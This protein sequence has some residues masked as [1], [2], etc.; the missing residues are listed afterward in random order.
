ME[1]F[2]KRCLRAFLRR[3]RPVDAVTAVLAAWLLFVFGLPIAA[4]NWEPRAN[5]AVRTITNVS[6]STANG[7]KKA[8]TVI[9]INVA[10]SGSVKPVYTS[11]TKPYLLLETGATDREAYI[12]TS[13]NSTTSTLAFSYTVQSGDLSSDLDYVSASS[14]VLN[15]GTIQDGTDNANLTLPTPGTAGSLGANA[16]LVIDGVR[17]T[18]TGVSSST[19]D[20]WY[21]VGDVIYVDVTFS[22]PVTQTSASLYLETGPSD[23]SAAYFAG[24]ASDTI[25]F[26]YQPS[27]GDG[28]TDL[29]YVATTSL[30][31]SFVDAAGNYA[32]TTLAA[33]GGAGSLSANKQIGVLQFT[34][35]NP[36]TNHGGAV[37]RDPA[38]GKFYLDGMGPSGPTC[39][40]REVSADASTISTWTS[41]SNYID[42][43]QVVGSDLYWNAS[44]VIYKSPLAAPSVSTVATATSKSVGAF[45]RLGGVNYVVVTNERKVYRLSDG[46]TTPVLVGS[47]PGTGSSLYTMYAAAEDGYALVGDS[48][49][50]IVYKMNL[51]TGA[52]TVHIDLNKCEYNAFGA[53]EN[54]GLRGIM[55]TA[56]GSEYYTFYS[57]SS[58]IGRRS[59]DGT[60]GCATLHDG[61]SNYI[62]ASF[63]ATADS[64]ALYTVTSVDNMNTQSGFMK[65][66]PN[67]QWG[68]PEVRWA[69]SGD[70]SGPSFTAMTVAS[71][72]L[73]ISLAASEN[74]STGSGSPTPSQFA[75]TVNGASLALASLS[76]SG[77]SLTLVPSSAIANGA[78]VRVVY[79]DV[80]TADDSSTVQDLTGNDAGSVELF[81]VSPRPAAPTALSLGSGT[82][83]GSSSSDRVTNATTLVVVGTAPAASTVQLYVGG[84][85]SGSTCTADSVTGAFSCSTAALPA[86]MVSITAI[87]TAAS[88]VTSAASAAMGVTIDTTAPGAPT[89]LVLD[90]SSDSGT[91]STDRLTNVSSPTINGTAEV[92]AVVQLFVGGVASG[93]GCAAAASTGSFACTTAV[94]TDGDRDISAVA[95]DAAGNSSA[96]STSITVAIDTTGPTISALNL[97]DLTCRPTWCDADFI[98]PTAAPSFVATAPNDTRAQLY[99]GGVAT[100]SIC[101]TSNG[102]GSG[103]FQCT[104]SSLV[105]GTYSVTAKLLDAAGNF[106]ANTYSARSFRVIAGYIPTTSSTVGST[107][108]TTTPGPTTTV[109]ATT[110]TVAGTTSTT[111]S[112]TSSSTTSTTAAPATTASTTSTTLPAVAARPV[113]YVDSETGSDANPGSQASPLRTFTRA[114]A[115]AKAGD[116]ID[117]TG[118]FSWS[119][120]AETGDVAGAGFRIAKA[121]TIRG[122]GDTKTVIE[123]GP[124]ASTSDRPV[125]TVSATVTIR[126]VAIR[127][128][129]VLSGSQGGGITN[130]AS[131]TLISTTVEDNIAAP[132]SRSSYY[133]AGGVFS[134]TNST[135]VIDK[136]T[137]RDN[138][139]TCTL[140]GAG[141][142]WA[143]QSVRKTITNSTFSGNRGSSSWGAT[144][145]FNY[146][147]VAGAFGTFR[148]GFTVITNSTFFGNSTDNYGGALVIYYQE[149]AHLTNVSVV[150]NSATRGA[151]GILYQSEWTG[152]NLNMKNVLAANNRTGSGNNDFHAYDA[153]TAGR[154]TE[155]YNLVESSTNKIFSG[156]GNITGPQPSLDLATSLAPNSGR[157]GVDTLLIGRDSVAKD[158]GSSTPNGARSPVAIPATDQ[159]GLSRAGAPDIGAFENQSET[160]SSAEPVVPPSSSTSTTSST[161]STTLVRATTTTAVQR[162]TTTVETVT[163]SRVTTT[164]TASDEAPTSTVRTRNA[165][166]PATTA[167]SGAATTTI[168]ETVINPDMV[169]TTVPSA[170]TIPER[171]AEDLTV[172]PKTETEIVATNGN[173]EIVLSVVDKSFS[174]IVRGE[175]GGLVAKQGLFAKVRAKG[176]MPGSLAEVW[177]FSTPR[178]LG[179]LQVSSRGE[180][181]GFVLI[182]D[183]SEIGDHRIEFRGNSNRRNFVKASVPLKI[184]ADAVVPE[185]IPPSA[186]AIASAVTLPTQIPAVII[187]AP[188]DGQVSISEDVIKSVLAEVLGDSFDLGKVKLR[189]RINKGEWRLIDTS[190]GRVLALVVPAASGENQ[191]EFEVTDPNGQ[192]IVVEREVLVEGT[193]EAEAYIAQAAADDG[194]SLWQWLLLVLGGAAGVILVGLA[195]RRRSRSTSTQDSTVV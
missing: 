77:S 133:N 172:E 146:A 118:T 110:G 28:T 9:T 94:L 159:R 46:S 145:P 188:V 103:T 129:R 43:F 67:F 178:L 152:Y 151:G 156:V 138:V 174:E 95:T 5:A 75:V 130:Q 15:G 31:G 52:T 191:I 91:S 35:S 143:L 57:A 10:F 136:S 63:Q 89:G 176:F 153:A 71:N 105:D 137:I 165:A 180:A 168:P 142:V 150:A 161:T 13:S 139:C 93:S 171:E 175:T 34:F 131:L 23:S 162:T 111:S 19:A 194:D 92:S 96:T 22:E 4:P 17:P 18:V 167:V 44:S 82:D 61:S 124:R 144:F 85:A 154:M 39:C 36:Q 32:V 90:A 125:F 21:G 127:H 88:G 104:T 53:T 128:G 101:S 106:S 183:D 49:S 163:A 119:D 58:Y 66:V 108:S 135:L 149:Y 69:D 169:A 3:P 117:L 12:T 141:G 78:S 140:Y 113:W 41:I 29:D 123:A 62:R 81:A 50:D 98:S 147:S 190:T 182:P 8:T 30:S 109:A 68:G 115:L 179:H 14:L 87:A 60:L 42:G 100:G 158:A 116:I 177:M 6:S 7:S 55:R 148:F 25:T 26:K 64:S 189:I 97:A 112:T 122:Q 120:P 1:K 184:L 134:G 24:S 164:T 166:L 102:A 160:T 121:I 70:V 84:V 126:D 47:V 195:L 86:G 173:V 79:S 16:A 54:P 83:T 51:S 193:P 33:P 38:S 114:Y 187:P 65:L 48:A 37:G 73:S 20:G 107:S 56:D 27:G 170:S 59:P 11:G 76:I 80:S 40:I 45:I 155:S 181:A 157:N 186:E 99:I 192:V 2:Y 132:S 185:T 72:G 74:L